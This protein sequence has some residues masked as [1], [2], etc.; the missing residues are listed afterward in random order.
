MTIPLLHPKICSEDL[1]DTGDGLGSNFDALSDATGD[2][3]RGVVIGYFLQEST[4]L[5]AGPALMISQKDDTF[6]LTG[7]LPADDAQAAALGRAIQ[8]ALNS[9]PALLFLTDYYRDREGDGWDGYV[10]ALFT[11]N[12]LFLFKDDPWEA[13]KSNPLDTHLDAAR[14]Q[15]CTIVVRPVQSAHQRLARA[16]AMAR[17]FDLFLA[18]QRE[19]LKILEAQKV[20]KIIPPST[21]DIAQYL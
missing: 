5:S 9:D 20:A 11:R 21:S 18:H 19:G 4:M 14:V 8:G 12:G 10:S 17:D 2:A 3:I 7:D 1:W 16:S 15:I 13:I 6:T